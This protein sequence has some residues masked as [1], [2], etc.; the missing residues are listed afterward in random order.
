MVVEHA[1]SLGWSDICVLVGTHLLNYLL[2]V[3]VTPGT[4]SIYVLLLQ[5][6]TSEEIHTTVGKCAKRTP[7]ITVETTM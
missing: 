7:D 1:R 6:M 5:F 3:K 4:L 2:H